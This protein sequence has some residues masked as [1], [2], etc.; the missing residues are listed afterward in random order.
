MRYLYHHAMSVWWL[1]FR[2]DPSLSTKNEHKPE[3]HDLFDRQEFEVFSQVD[4]DANGLVDYEEAK[5]FIVMMEKEHWKKETITWTNN[6]TNLY[7]GGYLHEIKRLYQELDSNGDG[8]VELE[9]FD[10]DL[11]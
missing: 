11:S 1:F 8:Y 10:K 9:K 2:F 6:E 7:I 5:N 3:L 4:A